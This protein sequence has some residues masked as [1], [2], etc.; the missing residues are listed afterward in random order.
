M[1]LT[2]PTHHVV[3]FS[4]GAGSWLA[5]KRVAAQHGVGRTKLLFT[6]PLV[7]DADNY[8]FLIQGACD[9]LGVPYDGPLRAMAE[10]LLADLPLPSRALM[11]RR[12]EMLLE[13][14]AVCAEHLP[15][16]A[17]I[18]D[19]RTPWELFEEERFLGN[20]RVDLC[21]RVLKREL[22]DSWLAANY[23]PAHTL[24]YVGIDWT[25]EHRFV[26]TKDKA[27]LQ[28][29]KAEMG[30]TYRAPLCEEPLI[31]KDEAFKLLEQLGIRRPRLY[32]QKASH[33]N[34]SR[35]CVKQ[36]QGDF[37]L[38]LQYTPEM[39]DVAQDWEDHV[40]ASIGKNVAIL[41]DRRGGTTR[42]MTLKE[43]RTRISGG[44]YD[45]D[46][47]GGCGCFVDAPEES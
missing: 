24:V 14:R 6:D 15:G 47:R 45:K 2:A 8:R 20:T 16:L 31:A 35:A 9:V 22:A 28:A 18:A 44:T 12:R 25:E 3:S 4:S 36:G 27:G 43:F 46:E 32:D 13:A 26:G 42:P 41:R 39:Y 30:W 7:E 5:G 23:N 10:H 21:S 40:I 34:C 11:A 19:G 1:N 38:L 17:W 29:R 33:S 37:A